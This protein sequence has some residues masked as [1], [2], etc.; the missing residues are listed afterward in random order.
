[1]SEW[2]F[3]QRSSA[4]AVGDPTIVEAQGI[5]PPLTHV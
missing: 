5:I 4:K 1:M 3:T 2:T